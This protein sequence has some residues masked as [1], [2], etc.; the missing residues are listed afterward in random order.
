MSWPITIRKGV[1][2]YKKHPISNFV[3][4]SHLSFEY[5]GFPTSI[6]DEKI[7]ALYEEVILDPRWKEAINE[8]LRELEKNQT[9]KVT[10]LPHGKSTVG[11]KWI[12]IK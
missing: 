6:Y 5:K 7:L 10:R 1:R 8:E 12:F 9:W 4:Y 11:Y 2:T 3:S